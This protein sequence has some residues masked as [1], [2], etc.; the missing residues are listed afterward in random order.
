[1]ILTML[2]KALLSDDQYKWD[3]DVISSTEKIDTKLESL[4]KYKDKINWELLSSNQIL[5]EIFNLGNKDLFSDFKSWINK[6]NTYLK[7]FENLWK[8][9]V[10]SNISSITWQQ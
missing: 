4:E 6:V 5:N 10:L 1:M 2:L 9:K 7:T 3:W 8:F